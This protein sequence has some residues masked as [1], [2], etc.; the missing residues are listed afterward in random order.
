MICK[1]P[2]DL[3]KLKTLLLDLTRIVREMRPTPGKTHDA[4]LEHI[5]QE[6]RK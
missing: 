3:A 1:C 5:E 2:S 4:M 6:L